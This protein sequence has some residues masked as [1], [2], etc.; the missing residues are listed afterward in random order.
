VRYELS[1]PYWRHF[2]GIIVGGL[3]L[4]LI[5]GLGFMTVLAGF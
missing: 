1:V 5:Y 4:P 3:E 2:H